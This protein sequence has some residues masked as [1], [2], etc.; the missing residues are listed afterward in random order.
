MAAVL[1][2]VAAAAMKTHLSDLPWW[3]LIDRYAMLPRVCS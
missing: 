1:P 2:F 3:S